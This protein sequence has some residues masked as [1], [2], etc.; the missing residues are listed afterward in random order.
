MSEFCVYVHE[1]VGVYAN[2][3]VL[4]GHVWVCLCV[5]VC[6]VRA[7]VCTGRCVCICIRMCLHV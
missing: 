6:P 7:S 4:F 2:V 3:S 1:C 5:C